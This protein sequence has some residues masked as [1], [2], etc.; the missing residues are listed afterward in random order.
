MNRDY[1]EIRLTQG[2]VALVNSED[3][4]FINKWKWR[5][6]SR[7]YAIRSE[8][9][10]GIKKY[11]LMHRI[12]NNTEDGLDTDHINRNKLD[13]R[14]NNLRSATRQQNQMNKPSVNGTSKYK[15]V[16]WNKRDE[17]WHSRIKIDGKLKHL[18][19]FKSEVE[20][21]KTYNKK[22]KELHSE[23]AVLNEVQND[24]KN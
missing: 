5:F 14:R 1:K 6:N 4:D 15:G 12:I 20:A 7:G 2:K 9:I 22:A 18:G 8:T 17:V 21:A 3:Y 11:I 24:R 10:N 23:F 13:N 19:Y 16:S